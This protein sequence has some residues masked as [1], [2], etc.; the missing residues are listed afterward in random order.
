MRGFPIEQPEI[1]D[2]KIVFG[3][4]T[5]D[6]GARFSR[7]APRSAENAPMKRHFGRAL[8][9]RFVSLR[10][11]YENGGTGKFAYGAV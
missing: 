2:R 4:C 7:L 1:F 9:K 10:A 5:D 6:V 3:R 11:K 8:E